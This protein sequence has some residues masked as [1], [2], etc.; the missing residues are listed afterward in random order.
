MFFSRFSF[1]STNCC[2][3]IASLRHLVLKF[4]SLRNENKFQ[5]QQNTSF[6]RELSSKSFSVFT[7]FIID[8]VSKLFKSKYTRINE[9]LR[10]CRI[11]KWYVILYC[12]SK[13]RCV[14]YNC[15][16]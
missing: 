9:A 5:Q 11:C 3:C 14:E 2:T 10:I 8:F 7:F 12:E 16:A 4:K 15:Y 1:L 6:C 13:V